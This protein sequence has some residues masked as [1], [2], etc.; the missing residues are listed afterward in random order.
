M[1]DKQIAAREE[2][3]YKA[4][5]NEWYAQKDEEVKMEGRPEWIFH[6]RLKHGREECRFISHNPEGGA[7]VEFTKGWLYSWAQD[8]NKDNVP[9]DKLEPVSCWVGHPERKRTIYGGISSTPEGLTWDK[10]RGA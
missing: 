3:K 6:Q 9:Y 1:I 4:E 8:Y 2:A 7:K 10:L 5:V